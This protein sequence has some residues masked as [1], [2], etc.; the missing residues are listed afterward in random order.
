MQSRWLAM[1]FAGA[2]NAA[3]APAGQPRLGRIEV[4]T[5]VPSIE[6]PSLAD[7]TPPSIA[8]DGDKPTVVIIFASW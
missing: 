5:P 8:R 4:G 2:L 1:M 7:G 6:L 3:G